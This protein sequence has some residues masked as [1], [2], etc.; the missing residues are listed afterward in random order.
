[1]ESTAL[2]MD[3]LSNRNE[4]NNDPINPAG[5]NVKKMEDSSLNQ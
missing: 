5:K 3:G 2:G 4:V 1:M